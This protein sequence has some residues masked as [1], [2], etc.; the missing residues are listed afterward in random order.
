MLFSKVAVQCCINVNIYVES[1]IFKHCYNV[2]AITLVKISSVR[3]LLHTIFNVLYKKDKKILYW[4]KWL[5]LDSWN[6]GMVSLLLSNK[7]VMKFKQF[8]SPSEMIVLF[9]YY[10][11]LLY[12]FPFL[13]VFVGFI[14]HSAV[15]NL[16]K[17]MSILQHCIFS[18]VCALQMCKHQ[19]PIQELTFI[20]VNSAQHQER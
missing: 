14:A 6:N 4:Y 8:I 16:L 12:Y 18:N 2:C 7:I 19:L 10:Y 1:I 20:Y 13:S 15:R 3:I 11:F 9:A 17:N 5:I